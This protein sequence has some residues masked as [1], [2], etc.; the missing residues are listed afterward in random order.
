MKHG[1]K[2]FRWEA[3]GLIVSKTQGRDEYTRSEEY[4][5]SLANSRLQGA[6]DFLK[7]SAFKVAVEIKATNF[8]N[9]GFEK[10]KAQVAKL[11]GFVGGFDTSRLDPSLDNNLQSYPDVP[12]PDTLPDEFDALIEDVENMDS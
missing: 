1:G 4:N 9:D 5:A 12:E 6:R 11:Q 8:V 3:A 7:S 2:L 10:C